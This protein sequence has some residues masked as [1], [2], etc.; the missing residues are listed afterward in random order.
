MTKRALHFTLFLMYLTFPLTATSQAVDI[1][2]PNLRAAIER[3][4]GIAPGGAITAGQ[5][6]TLTY[7]EAGNS[8]ISNLTGVAG[9]INLTYLNLGG[10]ISDISP[11]AGLTNLTGLHLSGNISDISAVAGLTNLTSLGLSGNIS[12]ISSVAGLTNLTDLYLFGNISDISAMAGLTNLTYLNLGGNNISDI[13]AVAGLTNLTSL[14]LHGSNISDISAVAGLTN[15]TDLN[16]DWNNISDISA[17]AGL[18][19]LTDLRLNG[20]SISDISAVAGLTKL[21]RLNLDGNNISDISAVAGLTNLTGLFL[22]ENSISDISAVAGLTKLIRL[23]LDGNNISDIS[24][25]AGLTNLTGLFLSE[26][27]ISD[28]SAL[29]GL[30]NLTASEWTP[31]LNLAGNAIEDLS[32][33]VANTGLGEGDRIDVDRNPLNAVSIHTHIPALRSRGV[34]VSAYNLKT[35]ASQAV[36]IPDPNLRT[37][38]ESALGIAPGGTITAEQM[39]TLTRLDAR[40]SDNISNLTGL[41]YAANLTWLFLSHNHI[42]D[43]SAVAGLTNLT[44]LQ[45]NLNNISDISAVAGL[46]DLE[47]L[48]L[49]GN[50][51]EDLSPLVANTG[52]GEGDEI[53]VDYNPLNTESIDTHIPAL[54]SR[55]V[56]VSAK[57]LTKVPQVPSQIVDIPDPNLRD[58]IEQ[59]LGISSGNTI[60]AG[61]MATLRILDAHGSNISSLTGLEYAINLEFLS[62]WGNAITD[63]SSVAGLTNMITLWLDRNNISEISAVAGLTDLTELTLGGNTISDI[64]AV[65]GL[66]NLTSLNLSDNNISGISA[67]AGLTNLTASE[68]SPSLN[69]AGNDIE[70]LSPLVANTGLGSGDKIDVGGNPLNSTSIDTH[71]PTLESRGVEVEFDNLTPR[72]IRIV[73][74]DDQQGMPGAALANPLVVEIQDQN[75]AAFEGVQ[76]TFTIA[77][78]GGALSVTSVT[79]DANGRAESTLTLGPNPGANTVTVSVTGIQEHQT[80]TAQGIRIPETLEIISGGGQEGPHGAMLENPFIV[81]VRDR[82]GEPLPGVQVMFSV[83][84]GGGTLSATSVAT[85]SKGRAASILTLG[86]DPGTNSVDVTVVGIT[87]TVTF[88]AEGIR[89]PRT[90]EIISGGGQEGLP[91]SA[92][93][94]PFVVEVQDQSDKP[95]PGVQVTFSITAGGGMLSATSVTTDSNGRAESILTLG[96]DPGANSVTV[97]VSGI[98]EKQTFTAQGVRIPETLEI[99]SGGGQEGPYGETLENPFIVEVRDQFDEPL[100]GVQVTFSVI[101]GGGTLSA[102]SVTTDRDG[103]AES[104]LTLGPDPGTNSV[105]VTAAGITRT[106]TFTAEGIRTPLAFWIITGFDQTGVIG[107]ALPRPIVIEVRDRAG[108]RLPG[109]EVTFSVASGGGTLSVTS[110]MTDSD[111]RAETVLTLGPDPGTNSVE[112][113]V[114]GLPRS[115]TAMA[116]AELPPIS[117][118]VNRDDVVNILDLVSVASVLGAEGADLAAD[119]N[120]DGI[121]N[122]LDLVMVAGALEDAAAAP[123]ADPRALTSLTAT[124]VGQ[125]LTQTRTLD[126]TDAISR[127]GVLFLERLLAALT[128][129]ETAL[130]PNYPNPFNPETWIPYHLASDAEVQLTIYDAKGAL[131]RRLALGHQGAGYYTDRNRAAYWDGRNQ[132]GDSVASGVY[133]Y[134]LRT[135]HFSAVRKMMIVK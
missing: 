43:I 80:F 74:G 40:G 106:E 42:S 27:S 116:F 59:A 44:Y 12:D 36:D 129:K 64:S 29:A 75:G 108:E 25:V 114:E 78:G 98:Q 77:S 112:V 70:D 30:T 11:V 49:L 107:E 33:L 121:V 92:L 96:P 61:Q 55:G 102:T 52:L 41:E 89:I 73:S 86:P 46:T 99:I 113:T 84:A 54:R 97:S 20:N 1:P 5:M 131:V 51:I 91:G 124:D 62:L 93:E 56:A 79:T 4:L 47:R 117:E 18:T 94:N 39:E 85:D 28:I 120:G 82:S 128:P 3:A 122:I 127:H 60:T 134:Q 67:L 69:L 57:G 19:N 22:S 32:P 50:A 105:D 101:A 103:R 14:D 83:T 81:E 17:V 58:V 123:S 90:L 66:T 132:R 45:L 133:F 6:A 104:I 35:P 76:V 9:L 88:A 13:S 26:N 130:L 15:L 126:L 2:D 109:V 23:N 68:F 53:I 111:G 100:P 119:V 38:I 72:S 37:A 118:D 48:N 125:W 8:N 34:E 135:E 63:I 24:A 110:A 10:N 31:S 95:L 115:Q 71:I 65:A 87:R 7:L 21:I 16:L